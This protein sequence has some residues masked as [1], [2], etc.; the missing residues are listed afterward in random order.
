MWSTMTRETSAFFAKHYHGIHPV[1]IIQLNNIIWNCYS[2]HSTL[3]CRQYFEC[4]NTWMV[5]LST[6]LLEIQE[7]YTISKFDDGTNTNG[8]IKYSRAT[9]SFW[10]TV[11]RI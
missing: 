10:Y 11:S 9:T 8:V 6:S 1:S 3:S 7:N 5:P 2:I 4:C